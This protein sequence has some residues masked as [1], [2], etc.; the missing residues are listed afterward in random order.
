[1]KITDLFE[2]KE[3]APEVRPYAYI[4]P[5]IGNIRTGI[6]VLMVPQIAMLFV[7]HSYSSLFVLL[8]AVVASMAGETLNMLITK[9]HRFEI[10]SPLLQGIITGLLL[11]Q[12]YSVYAVF[13]ITLV[14]M[15]LCKYAFG[16][17][18]STWVNSA[19]VAV[20]V[21]YMLN[22]GKF[23][24]QTLSLDVLQ[25]KNAALNLIQDPSFSMVPLDSAVTS[26]LNRTVFHFF[27][28]VIPEGYVS[29]FWDT[30][31]AIPAFRFNLITMISSIILISLDLVDIWIP[32]VFLAVY[33]V[34]VRLCGPL[35]LGGGFMQGDVIMAVLTSGTLFST[36]YMLQ[37][38]GTIP[39]TL[40]GK[41]V[42]GAISGIFA[43]LI[44][45]CGNSSVGYAFMVLIVNL[46]SSMIQV[47]E[48]HRVRMK[49]ENVLVPRMNA[50]KEAGNV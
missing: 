20:A 32:A 14:S 50:I 35:L 34:L 36:M 42:Y 17:G 46:I 8:A 28:I 37:W 29:L 45:G 6:L 19:A 31:S 10:M 16:G 40:P 38:F 25:S 12:G 18:A 26:F 1:M 7:T 48:S 27:G 9:S 39:V 22:T 43:F 23:P 30:G 15:L 4:T 33:A 41:M 13:F 21:A 2:K 47:F 44:M 3:K 5:S 11:P 24:V 49:I